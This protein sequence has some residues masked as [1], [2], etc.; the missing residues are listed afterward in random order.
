MISIAVVAVVL[1]LVW[2]VGELLGELFL[3]ACLVE[4]ARLLW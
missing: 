4:L 1:A 2:F 3:I